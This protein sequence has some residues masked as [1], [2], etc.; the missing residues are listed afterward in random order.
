MS[1]LA[2]SLLFA[3]L[4]LPASGQTP[5]QIVLPEPFAV[6]MPAGAASLP[7]DSGKLHDLL[8]AASAGKFR[9]SSDLGHPVAVGPTL[10]TFTAWDGARA[11][12]ARK[13]TLFVLPS[14]F[15][16]V[17]RSADENATAGNNAVHIASD[18]AGRVH[19]IWTDSGRQGALVGAKYRRAHLDDAGAVVWETAET[20]LAGEVQ[21]DWNAYPAL[22]VDGESVDFVWQNHGHL[23]H[24]RLAPSD[25]VLVWGAVHDTGLASEGR[26]TGPSLVSSGDTIAAIAPSGAVAISRDAGQSWKIE[27]IAIPAGGKVKTASLAR[28]ADGVLHA[29]MSVVMHNSTKPEGQGG[30]GGYWRLLAAQRSTSGDWSAPQDALAGLPAWASP[31]PN[32][33]AL[34]DWV[35]IEVDASGA[36]HL[37]WHGTAVSREYGHDQSWYARRGSAGKVLAP[38]ALAPTDLAHG[39]KYS[40]APSLT[41]DGDRAL[42]LTFFDV[43]DGAR[44]A[45]FDSQLVAF[46]DGKQQGAPLAITE[47]S[48][49]SIA[50]GDR[51]T[52]LSAR[53]P[54]AAPNLR[55][56]ADGHVWL[57][58]L[59]TLNPL[60]V[61][62]E[63][64]LVV[65]QRVDL[66]A[67]G[68]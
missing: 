60:N 68:M 29:A 12:G 42:A 65:Y 7:A 20:P 32:E 19:M 55:R 11:V 28:G 46:R 3:L 5:A 6:E 40:F 8:A 66:T 35:R 36:E 24:R 62:G 50:S 22:A 23:Q 21:A 25:G 67:A 47:F 26:D 14:G 56:G 38:A 10:V 15:A 51:S 34:A 45:G 53:F 48:R 63:A 57:D 54:S 16:P 1:R 59:H 9:V 33:D 13:A 18:S 37:A 17:G 31:P 43:F 49:R 58:V 27:K 52:E 44:W 30:G 41:L 64:A 39:V 61:D 2:L 4:C